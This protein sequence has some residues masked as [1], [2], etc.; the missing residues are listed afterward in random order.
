PGTQA[1][2]AKLAGARV[3]KKF[4]WGVIEQVGGA[5]EDKADLVHDGG[6]VWEHLGDPHAGLA[7]APETPAR[8][9]QLGAMTAGHEGKPFAFDEGSRDRLAVQINQFGLVI[10]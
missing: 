9:Q 3:H 10:K 5:R 1:R 8:A 2:P 6:G 4:G 7:M